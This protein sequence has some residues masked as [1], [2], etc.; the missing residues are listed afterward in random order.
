MNTVLIS[1]IKCSSL[2]LLLSRSS[3]LLHLYLFATI[4]A[5]PPPFFPTLSLL[6][7]VNPGS[8]ILLIF[9]FLSQVSL[10]IAISIDF[11]VPKPS[12]KRL[13]SLCCLLIKLLIFKCKNHRSDTCG[14]K[15]SRC[16][17]SM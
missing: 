7:N 11:A 6:M 10:S 8:E 3:R 2:Q 17:V 13:Y 4:I 9:S 12:V 5:T 1:T 15:L 16:S 14:R